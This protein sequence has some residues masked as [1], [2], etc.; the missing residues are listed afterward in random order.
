MDPARPG[1]LA[2]TYELQ[3]ASVSLSFSPFVFASGFPGFPEEGCVHVSVCVCVCVRARAHTHT[4]TEGFMA[5]S[6]VYFIF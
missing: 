3:R 2:F 4:V 1:K 6:R 5:W